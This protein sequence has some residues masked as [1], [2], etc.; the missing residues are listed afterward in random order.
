MFAGTA[1]VFHDAPRQ[2][3]HRVVKQ[4]PAAMAPEK[5][6][7]KPATTESKKSTTKHKKTTK[8]SKTS[9]SKPTTSD[10]MSKTSTSK[11][12]MGKESTPK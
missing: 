10:S 3:I 4:A 1:G 5:N 6:E 2:P 9:K 12:N 11:D 7:A 8:K